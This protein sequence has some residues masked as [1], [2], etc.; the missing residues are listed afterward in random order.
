MI[1]FY[2]CKVVAVLLNGLFIVGV[3]LRVHRMVGTE[4]KNLL[5]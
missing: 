4:S 2:F 5:L 3:G 1:E